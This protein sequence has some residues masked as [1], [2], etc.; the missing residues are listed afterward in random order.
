MIWSWNPYKKRVDFFFPS[1][2][3]SPD[4]T[5]F[6]KSNTYDLGTGY[7]TLVCGSMNNNIEDFGLFL[8][9]K[10]VYQTI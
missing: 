6:F 8:L 3:N 1:F 10:Y 9:N 7:V 4:R 5:D 2:M